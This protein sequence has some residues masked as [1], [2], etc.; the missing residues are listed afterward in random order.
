VGVVLVLVMPDF[1]R[2][3]FVRIGEGGLGE[4][5]RTVALPV[6]VLGL[7]ESAQ[8]TRVLR[9]D[10]STT[11]K[12]DF[13]LASRAQGMPTRHIL[14]KEALRPSTFSLVT[15]AGISFG[16]LLGGTVIVETIF[17]L[18]GMGTL[19]VESVAR[20]EFM[21]LQAAVLTVA[22]LY[23]L[24]NALVDISY[25]YLDPRTRHVRV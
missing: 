5:L 24:V 19:I 16:R 13:V 12:D 11:L 21:V 10:M 8:L 6:L 23:V 7:A 18:P 9:S 15:V 2:Q 3:G 22:A 20:K 14:L 1:P 25:L 17:R 4:N